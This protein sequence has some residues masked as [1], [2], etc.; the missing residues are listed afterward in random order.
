MKIDERVLELKNN[1]RLLVR[2]LTAADAEAALEHLK[3]TYGET[4]YLSMYAD[5][6]DMT[7]EGER[8]F[9]SQLEKDQTSFEPYTTFST[10]L[11]PRTISTSPLHAS[12]HFHF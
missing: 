6:V 7:T 11:S 1:K 12:P 2:T 3:T 5:E 4:D 9:L 8:A 10:W